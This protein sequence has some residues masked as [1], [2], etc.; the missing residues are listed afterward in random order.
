MG[1]PFLQQAPGLAA[2]LRVLGREVAL[3]EIWP[4]GVAAG[5]PEGVEAGG[6]LVVALCGGGPAPL[7]P[8][9]QPEVRRRVP[10]SQARRHVCGDRWRPRTHLFCAGRRGRVRATQRPAAPR[11]GD[12]SS[13]GAGHKRITAA[14]QSLHVCHAAM[15]QQ[16]ATRRQ[17]NKTLRA[18]CRAR[19]W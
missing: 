5:G 2:A 19:R 18:R 9:E 7:G 16:G 11:V 3:P 14:R 6:G 13:R 17:R 8:L 1:V 15:A 10:S 12:T 4:G